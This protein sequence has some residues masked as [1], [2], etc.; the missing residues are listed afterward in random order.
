M[1]STFTSITEEWTEIEKSR[2]EC[3]NTLNLYV[4]ED[5]P[6]KPEWWSEKDRCTAEGGLLGLLMTGAAELGVLKWFVG[7]FMTVQNVRKWEKRILDGDDS[8]RSY[9]HEHV[10]PVSE[11]IVI[12]L[13][14]LRG[15]S[16]WFSTL[17]P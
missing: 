5:P 14:R 2:T 12:V 10:I 1:S 11:R 6:D 3:I 13:S 8:L 17:N 15:L 4:N 16:I 9:L 7:K